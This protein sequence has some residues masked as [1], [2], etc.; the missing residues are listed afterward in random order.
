MWQ[1]FSHKFVE[2][3]SWMGLVLPLW[4][5]VSFFVVQIVVYL[6]LHGLNSA[7]VPITKLN[8]SVL[9]TLSSSLIYILTI[10]MVIGLP[11]LIKRY[12]TSKEDLGLN[13]WPSWLDL[14]LGPTGLIIYMILSAIL[15][16][17]TPI[18]L[19]FINL[20]QAQDIGFDRLFHQYEYVF[21]FLTLVVIAPVAEEILFRGYLFGK[22]RKH[23][24]LWVAIVLTSLLFGFIHGQWNV[25]I[26][27]FALSVVSCLL[28]VVSKSLWPS[29]MLHMLKNSIAFYFLF[30]NPTLLSTLGG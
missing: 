24:P 27:V 2:R 10:A 6:I 12:R 3:K 25:A 23:M 16:V 28:R 13:K 1:N 11:W 4:V 30:I 29:I 21:A 9:N 17:I 18:I 7:G 20:E 8:A 14:L 5:L 19:P 15:L 26:D 22:L